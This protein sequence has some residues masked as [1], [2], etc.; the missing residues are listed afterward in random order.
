VKHMPSTLVRLLAARFSKTD[1]FAA[2][3][4]SRPSNCA[5]RPRGTVASFG[6]RI[7]VQIDAEAGRRER[8]ATRWACPQPPRHGRGRSGAT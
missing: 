4:T 8:C 1:Q 6:D 5:A 2:V 7:H 3:V